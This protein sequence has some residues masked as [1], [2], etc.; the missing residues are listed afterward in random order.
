MYHSQDIT[1]AQV[2]YLTL[3]KNLKVQRFFERIKGWNNDTIS[4]GR[5]IK[6]CSQ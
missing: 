4:V 2:M 1:Y 5:L 6:A 3:E